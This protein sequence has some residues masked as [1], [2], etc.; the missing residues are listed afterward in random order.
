ML[1]DYIVLSKTRFQQFRVA[2][3]F[4]E[5]EFTFFEGQEQQFF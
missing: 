2:F 1:D 3:D 5:D 4:G